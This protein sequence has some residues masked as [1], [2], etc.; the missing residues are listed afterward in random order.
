MQDQPCL[1][2]WLRQVAGSRAQSGRFLTQPRVR[3]STNL[4]HLLQSA[5]IQIVDGLTTDR[6]NAIAPPDL[7]EKIEVQ[8]ETGVVV[9]PSVSHSPIIQPPHK[10]PVSF[11]YFVEIVILYFF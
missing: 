5:A 9:L 11:I 2:N 1:S 7:N 8:N 4:E 6:G 3:I 10:T